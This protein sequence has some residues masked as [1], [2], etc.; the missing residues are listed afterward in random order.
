M[1]IRAG[2]CFDGRGGD[3]EER[4]SGGGRGE[5]GEQEEPTK[6]FVAVLLLRP[7]DPSPLPLPSG[8]VDL[9][10][11]AKGGITSPSLHAAAMNPQGPRH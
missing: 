3:G 11:V 1:S 7:C 2:R 10:A 5:R 4:K 9:C 6:A 8:L